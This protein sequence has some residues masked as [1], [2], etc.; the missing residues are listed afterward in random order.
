MNLVCSQNAKTGK[1]DYIGVTEEN[2]FVRMHVI[3]YVCLSTV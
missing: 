2:K 1:L 3:K